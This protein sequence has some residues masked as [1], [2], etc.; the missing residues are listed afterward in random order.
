MN[1]RKVFIY[2]IPANQ[3]RGPG[4]D[5]LDIR[6]FILQKTVFLKINKNKTACHI[7][8]FKDQIHKDCKSFKAN[9]LST[10]HTPFVI[11][12]GTVA[13]PCT[14][15]VLL[16]FPLIPKTAVCQRRKQFSSFQNR[17]AGGE[18]ENNSALC[19]VECELP[20]GAVV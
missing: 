5:I 16:T 14:F 1:S 17:S 13:P 19:K 10:K 7:W 18:T 20:E 4:Q 9:I 8:F 11:S 3:V 2:I 15:A 12:P 6:L